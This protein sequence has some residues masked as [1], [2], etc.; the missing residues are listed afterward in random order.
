[1]MITRTS[2]ISRSRSAFRSNA[3]TAAGSTVAEERV[4]SWSVWHNASASGKR[5][6]WVK[7]SSRLE[8]SECVA[9]WE[10]EVVAD[11]EKSFPRRDIL[12]LV[13]LDDGVVVQL[14]VC[15]LALHVQGNH[16]DSFLGSE[17]VR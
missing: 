3:L 6:L 4:K 2:R 17:R 10:E 5:R 11:A 16:C 9:R 1:M 12:L 8:S 13:I 7:A 14:T 15:H